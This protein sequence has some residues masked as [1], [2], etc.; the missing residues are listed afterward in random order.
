MTFLV[1]LFGVGCTLNVAVGTIAYLAAKQ[2]QQDSAALAKTRRDVA[3]M[4]VELERIRRLAYPMRIVSAEERAPV[5]F[6]VLL[7]AGLARYE[8]MERAKLELLEMVA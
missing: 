5:S 7:G 1:F 3:Q 8:S 2:S 6:K 4:L